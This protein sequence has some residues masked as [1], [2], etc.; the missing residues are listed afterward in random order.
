MFKIIAAVAALQAFTANLSAALEDLRQRIV[1]A[2]LNAAAENIVT[3]NNKFVNVRAAQQEQA[4]RAEATL[5]HDIELAYAAH[6]A[7]LKSI[8]EVC[9]QQRNKLNAKVKGLREKHTKLRG[10]L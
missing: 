10:M 3:N 8:G 1:G 5:K 4:K 6:S 7:T 2:A 9:D